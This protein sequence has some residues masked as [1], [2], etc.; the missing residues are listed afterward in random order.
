VV[1]LLQGVRLVA[2]DF[3]GHGLSEHADSYAYADY[4]SDLTWALDRLGLDD[5]TVA[6]HSLGIV[7]FW[8][9]WVI[10]WWSGP[11]GNRKL[12][13]VVL[14]IEQQKLEQKQR[15]EVRDGSDS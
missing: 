10:I 2:L 8:I 1:P 6:G 5:V 14:R 9:Q 7:W 3:R 13:E 4:E 11:R 15:K 12:G